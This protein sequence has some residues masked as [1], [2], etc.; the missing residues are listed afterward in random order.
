MAQIFGD[1]GDTV[2]GGVDVGLD[3]AERD[4]AICQIAVTVK[5]GVLGVLPSLLEQT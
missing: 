4:G 1:C 2:S 5:D 3:L